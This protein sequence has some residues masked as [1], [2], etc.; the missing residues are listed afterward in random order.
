MR[1]NLFHSIQK[2]LFLMGRDQPLG[3]QILN[4]VEWH[5]GKRL[6]SPVRHNQ[7]RAQSLLSVNC[8]VIGYC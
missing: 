1:A 3:A 4:E 2:K 6:T 5:S 8:F 7:A